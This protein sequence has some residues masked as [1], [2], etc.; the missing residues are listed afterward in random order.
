MELM[1]KGKYI[2]SHHLR[3]SLDEKWVCEAKDGREQT[4]ATSGKHVVIQ[5]RDVNCY[6]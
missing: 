4:T 2:Y 6:S 1:D 5:M 3:V